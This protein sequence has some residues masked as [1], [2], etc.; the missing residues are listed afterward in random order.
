MLDDD[1]YH[2]EYNDVL[3]WLCGSI[4]VS[5]KLRAKSEIGNSM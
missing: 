1:I 4:N 2:R 3:T 5:R